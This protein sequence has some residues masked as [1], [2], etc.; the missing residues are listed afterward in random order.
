METANAGA[1]LRIAEET[2]GPQLLQTQEMVPREAWQYFEC[3]LVGQWLFG[4][5]DALRRW[6]VRAQ[7]AFPAQAR[8]LAARPLPLPVNRAVP[9]VAIPP[10]LRAAVRGRGWVPAM[11]QPDTGAPHMGRESALPLTRLRGPSLPRT[12]RFHTFVTNREH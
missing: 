11:L 5:S 1:A 12:F 8:V 3:T 9:C 7:H 10:T 6:G 2:R 4:G